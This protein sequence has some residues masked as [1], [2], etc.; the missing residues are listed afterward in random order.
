MEGISIV[1]Q[2]GNV[3]L[4]LE[5]E[6]VNITSNRKTLAIEKDMC[7][8]CVSLLKMI[9][10]MKIKETVEVKKFPKG[11]EPIVEWF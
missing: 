7:D 3:I 10:Q 4:R 5:I 2:I 8:D 9:I 6:K 1:D 11:D